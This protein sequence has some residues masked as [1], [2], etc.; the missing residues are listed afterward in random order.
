MGL[1]PFKY[2]CRSC[3]LQNVCEKLQTMFTGYTSFEMSVLENQFETLLCPEFWPKGV[4]LKEFYHNQRSTRNSL[5]PKELKS[6]S[7]NSF[8]KKDQ[9]SVNIT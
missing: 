7:E 3:N 9:S 4:F 8:L 5:Q 6:G 2:K 1:K